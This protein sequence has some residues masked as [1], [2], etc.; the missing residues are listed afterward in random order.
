MKLFTDITKGMP[1]GA[2]ALQENFELLDKGIKGVP[3]DGGL[4]LTEL[5]TDELKVKGN[6]FMMEPKDLSPYLKNDFY[7]K[8]V[9]LQYLIMGK[10][11]ILSGTVYP[12]ETM[13]GTKLPQGGTFPVYENLPFKFV[14]EQSQIRQGSGWNT[15]M[16]LTE[17][18]KLSIQKH[19][20]AGQWVPLSK[21][22]YLNVSGTFMIE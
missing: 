2:E 20:R 19:Q 5:N 22:G 13:D 6:V 4:Q 9:K 11:V 12:K 14:E 3:E 1:N 7:S 16:L 10:V 17:G 15:F 21:G 8:D 18:E